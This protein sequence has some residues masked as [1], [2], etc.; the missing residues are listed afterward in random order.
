MTKVKTV[1][2]VCVSLLFVASAFA[3]VDK[4]NEM[5][6]WTSATDA[7]PKLGPVASSNPGMDAMWD[8]L[9]YFNAGVN[10]P[11]NQLLGCEFAGGHYFAT[12]GGNA[13]D[14]NYVYKYDATGAL[15]TSWTQWS[16]T[17]WGWRDLAY[18][19]TYLY[20]SVDNWV[21]C[22]D[23]NGTSVPALDILGPSN[24]NRS[25]AYD[26][27]T[28]H[29]WTGNFGS[30]FYEFDR[31]GNVIWTG[32]SPLTSVYGMAWDDHTGMLWIH[33]QTGGC[34][35]HEYDPVAHALTGTSYLVP[36]VGA[37]TSQ[38]A[39]GLAMTNEA[40][41]AYWTIVGM[42][43][44][45]PDD[46]IFVLEM[47]DNA[48][49]LAPNVPENFTLTPGAG[50]ALTCDLAWDLPTTT[51]NGSPIGSYPITS[52]EVMRD[53]N[54]LAT[55]AAT[56]TSYSDAVT[57]AGN[58]EYTVYCVNSYG[59]GIPA[60]AATWIGLDVPG[61]VSSLTGAGVGTAH[62]V[63]LDWVNPTAGAHGGYWPA[64]S[65]DGY[66][67]ER[68]GPDP[69]TLNLTGIATS[70]YDNTMTLD[71]WYEYGV[72]AYN[73]SG[74]GPE[75]L[76][77]SFYVGEPE[78]EEIPYAWI[79]I[80]PAHPGALP[81][82]DTGITGDDQNLG[83]FPIGFNFP[84]Y[85]GVYHNSIRACSNGFFTFTSTL[86]SYSNYAIP[87]ASAPSDLV[88]PYWDDMNPSG[89]YGSIWYYADPGGA[90]F[91]MEVDSMNHYGSSYTG[92][93]YTFEAIFYPDGEIHFMYKAIEHG[94]FPG[95]SATVGI[96]NA[97]GTVGAQCTYN[98]SGP[99]E[100][101]TGMGIRMA[102]VGMP[103]PT[104]DI[105]VDLTYVGGSP[106]PAGG[107][108]LDFDVFVENQDTVPAAFDA[109]LAVAYEGGAP[110]TLV[111]RS[112]TNYLPGW[113]INR[114]GMYY[115]VPG[116]WPA[117]NYDFYL[118]AGTEP[119]DV[120]DE[121]SFPFVKSGVADG[122]FTGELPLPANAP[123]PFDQINKGENQIPTSYALHG[124]YPNPFNP[125]A[126]LGYA[127]PEASKVTL[128]VYDVSGR[129]VA[130]L[131]NGWRDAGNHEAVFDASSLASGVYIYNLTAGDFNAT[132]K[133]VLMK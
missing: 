32:A 77:G 10:A 101:V 92:D 115:P 1:F 36:L 24:P 33:D 14:P 71:G 41:P 119:T 22:F 61:G 3:N 34:K 98:G 131:I 99:L 128:T 2:I 18:D 17:G 89:A 63:N 60:T 8:M 13:A 75:V 94:T 31:A 69:A 120:W 6:A 112:F 47:Y 91:V 95:P 93:Y 85:D 55:L 21:R 124:V 126:T 39:G 58:Y 118:R 56:A 16:S 82:T 97:T 66:T 15:V 74:N 62:E 12:G 70:Y 104:Y 107:G 122:S 57:S 108:N 48:D 49:P 27:V 121:D 79:E 110:N 38:M 114:P 83:P 52:V 26:P 40:N 111:L 78:F 86:T 23:L 28:D 65:I 5:L 42:T 4:E 80:N 9:F 72:V 102:P 64:G 53:G 90:F 125:T 129:Q 45:T 109:W 30:P 68:Y 127:L 100:P 96:Q 113:T 25:L 88:A 116:G 117:G 11:D 19:G 59:D 44:G 105:V 106:V 51:V 54:P 133:M 81:G 43:Q 123:N 46:M 37:S 67:I 73:A 29:F 50:G 7:S 103:S 84:W 35:I 76:T 87:S 132:G 20:G 130:E